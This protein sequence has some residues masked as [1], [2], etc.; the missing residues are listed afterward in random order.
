VSARIRASLALVWLPDASSGTAFCIRS[1]PEASLYVTGAHVLGD[2]K[3]ATLYRQFPV[4]EKMP[5]SVLASGATN[6]LDLAVVSVPTGNIPAVMLSPDVLDCDGAVA[7]AGY[8]RVQMWAADM[9]GE[10][11]PAIHVGTVISVNRQGSVV[12]HDAISRPGNSGGPLFDSATGNVV[13]IEKSGWQDEET[14]CAI[15]VP[16]LAA[17]LLDNGALSASR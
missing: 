3:V 15:G 7:L 4:F 14:G 17:F 6:G 16:V 9:L 13:G 5:G 1:T 10:V 8:A 11:T 12:M 2:S